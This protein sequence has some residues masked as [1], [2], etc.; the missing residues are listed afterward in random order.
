MVV[1]CTCLKMAIK[2]KNIAGGI[3]K[4]TV[5]WDLG[6]S[7]KNIWGTFDVVVFI[8]SWAGGGGRFVKFLKIASNQK[9]IRIKNQSGLIFWT[10]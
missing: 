8:V 1:W 7:V 9:K 6:A 2:V 4:C 5:I 3:A 10:Q